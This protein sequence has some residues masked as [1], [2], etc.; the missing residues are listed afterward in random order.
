MYCVRC[1]ARR[2]R[3]IVARTANFAYHK[4][5]RTCIAGSWYLE[6]EYYAIFALQLHPHD[7]MIIE[8]GRA[9]PRYIFVVCLII[10]NCSV[11]RLYTPPSRSIGSIERNIYRSK[12]RMPFAYVQWARPHCIMHIIW[13]TSTTSI[14]IG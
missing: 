6:A 9:K 8:S 2:P 12:H 11:R 10:N 1:S 5:G 13:C 7:E 3:Y 14:S 4:M